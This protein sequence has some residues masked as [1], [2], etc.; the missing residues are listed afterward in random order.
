MGIFADYKLYKEYEPQYA[1]WKA[2]KDLSEAQKLEYLKNN[3]I[4]EKTKNAEIQRGKA[5]LNALDVMDE[6]SQSRAENMEVAT[7]QAMGTAAYSV[8]IL[9][10]ALGTASLK[11]KSVQNGLN[12]LIKT[13]PKLKNYIFF[14]PGAIGLLGSMAVAMCLQGWAAGK[15]V[16]AS[17]KGRFEAMKN[18]LS[19]VKN[20]AV[21]NDEQKAKQEKIASTIQTT[22][23]MKKGTS[24]KNSNMINPL[25]ALKVFKEMADSDEQFDE[26]RK[27]FNESLYNGADNSKQLSKTDIE[28]AK[29]DQQLLH[30][31][32][33]KVDMASQDYAE[34]VELATASVTSIGLAG[35][36]LTGWIANQVI[37]VLKITNSKVVKYLPTAI[38]AAFSIGTAIA[39][40]SLQK[41]ASRVGRYLA[42]KEI[43]KDMNNF[44]YVDENKTKDIKDVKVEKKKKPNFFKFIIQAFKNDAEYKKYLKT[45]GVENI[46]KQMALKDIDLTPEQIKEAK[47]LQKNSF[48]AFSK[49][50]E[51][52]QKYA[53]SIEAVGEVIGAPI[54]AAGGLIGMLIGLAFTKKMLKSCD[55]TKISKLKLFLPTIGGTLLGVIPG[56][57]NNIYFTKQQKQASRVAHM[58][59]L[60]EMQD[61]K[62]YV[63][64]ENLTPET[65]ANEPAKTEEMQKQSTS[66]LQRFL[67][68]S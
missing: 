56:I 39:A 11:L 42:K 41:Q 3:P 46:K 32:I 21:L 40:A 51:K 29:K 68:K 7:S 37:K 33:E 24:A 64:Y 30:N 43:E 9:G 35:G 12:K 50:D 25:N 52:S 18:E 8:N 60:N 6:Y 14:I 20:F 53:E 16:G 44:V 62:N 61:Y 58:L 66:M 26:E 23:D 10:I 17:R 31:I 45:K 19:D 65:S 36:L 57:I 34:N 63:D 4:D 27:A 59:A 49:L 67:V 1:D 54:S 55:L 5:L 28:N 13:F 22:G 47:R 38:G 2:A 48:K 15:E